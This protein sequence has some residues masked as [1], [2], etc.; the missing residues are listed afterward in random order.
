ME[1]ALV[2]PTEIYDYV[3]LYASGEQ[4]FNGSLPLAT[5][6]IGF[7]NSSLNLH[8]SGVPTPTDTSNVL[9]HVSGAY[10]SS[11]HLNLHALNK[12]SGFNSLD[13]Y[14]SGNYRVES[15]LPLFA[16][17]NDT[18]FPQDRFLT[19]HTFGHNTY[20]ELFRSLGLVSYSSLSGGIYSTDP[21]SLPKSEVSLFTVAAGLPAINSEDSSINLYTLGP[22]TVIEKLN[23][24]LFGEENPGLVEDS[25][26]NLTTKC[27][28]AVYLNGSGNPYMSWNSKNFGYKTE[29]QDEHLFNVESNDLIRGVE[30]ICYGDCSNE[31][32]S[33]IEENII[34][35]DTKWLD[36]SCVDGGILRPNKTYR[37]DTV[38]AF[39]DE[40]VGPYYGHFYGTRKYQGLYPN[41]P[42][43][44]T[45]VGRKG[46]KTAIN[47]PPKWEEWEF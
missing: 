21:A 36:D 47:V 18:S 24:Y 7:S 12:E 9:L 4:Y 41:S 27:F 22:N 28:P 15:T 8:M 17:N 25:L 38:D 5:D 6:A 37:N 35:H 42:Y 2:H 20:P 34:T 31:E 26:V 19:L 16:G 10:V 39:G 32:N 23:L 1:D 11:N 3:G 29:E 45:V 46:S 44:V 33:C 40:E 14:T 43:E 13:I 30:T